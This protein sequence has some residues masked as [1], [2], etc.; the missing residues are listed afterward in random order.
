MDRSSRQRTNKATEVLNDI[1]EEL[2]LN[3]IFMT[4]HPKSTE[5]AFFSSAHQTFSRI[6]HIL[7]HKTDL[8]KFKV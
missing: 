4:L 3:D 6:N 7:G 1:I 8:N 5:Y 2:D